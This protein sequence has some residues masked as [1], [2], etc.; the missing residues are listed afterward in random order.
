MEEGEEKDEKKRVHGSNVR[1][2]GEA[3]DGRMWVQ[4]KIELGLGWTKRVGS[5]GDQVRV[6]EGEGVGVGAWLWVG[7][8]GGGE[9][10]SGA[11]TRRENQCTNN[12][13]REGRSGGRGREGET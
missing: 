4:L 8:L 6:G 12:Q 13:T 10:G 5:V 2:D 1:S 11:H 9:G 7:V 3:G